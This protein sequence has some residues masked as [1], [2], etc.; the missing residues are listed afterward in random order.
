MSVG[1]FETHRD[2]F[3]PTSVRDTLYS[4]P[5]ANLPDFA[6][7]HIA[8]ARE[9]ATRRGHLGLVVEQCAY[10]LVARQ[11]ETQVIPAAQAYGVGVFAWSRCT[12]GCSAARSGSW[13]TAPR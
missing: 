12:A 11:A 6:G 10:N 13:P 7:W 4:L 2:F 8:A 9:T 3:A 5:P 1:F